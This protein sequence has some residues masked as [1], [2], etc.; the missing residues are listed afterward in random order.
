MNTEETQ[1]ENEETQ[2]ETEE[3]ILKNNSEE[4]KDEYGDVFSLTQK[5]SIEFI[6]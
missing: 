2:P 4:K 6:L 3:L 1:N 5:N